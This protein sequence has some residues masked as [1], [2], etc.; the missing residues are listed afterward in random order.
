M[1]RLVRIAGLANLPSSRTPMTRPAERRRACLICRRRG[2]LA[3]PEPATLRSCSMTRRRP[4]AVRCDKLSGGVTRSRRSREHN[5][6]LVSRARPASPAARMDPS[7]L[8]RQPIER[9]PQLT[10][11]RGLWQKQHMRRMLNFMQDTP[12]FGHML[13]DSRPGWLVVRQSRGALVQS[14]R[15]VHGPFRS[16]NGGRPC[17]LPRRRTAGGVLVTNKPD[18]EVIQQV[19][20]IGFSIDSRA[21][22][23]G[24]L[25][26]PELIVIF[27]IALVVFGPRK[28]PELGRS[29]TRHCRVQ[30]GDERAAEH[31][32]TGNQRRRTADERRCGSSLQRD[33]HS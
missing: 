25:G 33:A 21:Q 32:R 26:M 30:E 13:R 18:T 7:A 6:P 23:V 8:T 31:A 19:R 17:A 9:G 1:A 3:P 22:Y 24:S 16:S 27:A 14:L 28:L 11:V 20:S 29:R 12:H 2:R 5:L 4:A 15:A 10:D